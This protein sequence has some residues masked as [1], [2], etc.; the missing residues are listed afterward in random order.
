LN[1]KF[2]KFFSSE[3]VLGILVAL[4]SVFIAAAAYQSSLFDSKESDMN[5]EGQKQL[6]ESNSMYLEANQFVIYDYQMYDGWYINDG[7]NADLA[8]YYKTSFSENLTTSMDR[9]AGPFDDQYYT[10]M[11]ADASST[12][13]DSMTAFDEANTA[14]NKA[15]SLQLVVLIYAVGLALAAYGS[16][17]GEDANLRK[18][19]GIL[20]IVSLIIGSYLY[21][22]TL[23]AVTL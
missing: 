17:L 16:M 7:T 9:E 23:V 1:S 20:S 13:D 2:M 10:E 19:F 14:G 8:D 6:T 22:S 11:Y 12:Y 4:L 18:F 5:V 21:I 15:D 3:W